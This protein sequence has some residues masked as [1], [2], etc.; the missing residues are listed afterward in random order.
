MV[1]RFFT[2]PLR[3]ALPLFAL[4]ALALAVGRAQSADEAPQGPPPDTIVTYREIGDTT[5]AMHVFIPPA[6]PGNAPHPALVLFFGGGWRHGSPNQFYR[7]ARHLAD[8]GLTVFLPEYRVENRHGTDPFACL[9]DA[10]AAMRWVRRHA[11]EWTLDHKRIGAG[12]GSA[13]A[14]LAAATAFVTGF[15]DPASISD[16]VSCAPDAL[17]LFNPVIDN[18]PDG[19]GYER[20]K[21]RFPAFSP[22]HNIGPALP[23]PTVVLLGTQ[24]DLI[25]VETGQDFAARIRAAGGRCDLHL[26]ETS[27]HGFFNFRDW[28]NLRYY[29]TLRA[30]ERFLASIGWLDGEPTTEIPADARL[31][32]SPISP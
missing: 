18:G 13:G 5:L 26:Y 17:V 20:I 22:L 7:Q 14:H 21:A 24:D 15:D 12:G 32:P 2:R 16:D 30:T 10:K 29:E 11:D 19:Y 3:R 23:P 9:A 1:A 8:R 4:L 27:A 25:P 6:L 31:S 28:G